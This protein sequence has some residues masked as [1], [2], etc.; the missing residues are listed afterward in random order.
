LFSYKYILLVHGISE[1]LNSDRAC[2]CLHNAETIFG[3]KV[4]C[5]HCIGSTVV[6]FML[7]IEIFVIDIVSYGGHVP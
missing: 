3:F 1:S 7:L 2:N 5:F 4:T 6:Q